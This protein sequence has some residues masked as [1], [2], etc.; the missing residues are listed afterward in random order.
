MVEKMPE[1]EDG[2]EGSLEP[3]SSAV[4]EEEVE[5]DEP[6]RPLPSI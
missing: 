3:K 5:E 2:G 6:T 4:K 1:D